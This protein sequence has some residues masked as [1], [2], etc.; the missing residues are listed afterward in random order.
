MSGPM[1]GPMR[2]GMR[3]GMKTKGSKKGLQQ[4][5]KFSKPYLVVILIAT[6]CALCSAI[7]SVVAPNKLGAVTDEITKTMFGSID[8]IAV[9][10]IVISLIG[11]YATS[12]VLSFIQ[13]FSM[14]TV[15]QK[16]AKRLRSDISH[17]INKLPLKCFDTTN[18]GDILS[19]I[20]NDVDL[21]AQSMNQSV[22]ALVSAIAL[23]LGSVIAMF[24]TNPIM[25]TVAVLSSILGF[26]FMFIV[27]GK[28]QKHFIAQQMLLGQLNGHIE[29]VYTGH[30]VVVAFNATN[31]LKQQ[32]NQT[33]DKLYTSAWKSQ[34]ASGIMMPMMHFIGNLGYVAVC[35]V[36]AVL[37]S[38]GKISFGVITS[39]I[40]YVRLF[41]QPLS[42]IGQ[43]ASSVQSASAASNRVFEFLELEET[44]D[45]SQKTKT[46]TNV[47]G[48]V[49]FEHVNFGYNADK[50]IINDF[51][52]NVVGG[53]KV[54]IVGPTGAG[55]T[56]LVNLLMRFY[57][58]NSGKISIDGVPINELTRENL[59]DLFGMVLQ[60]TWLFHGT[61][62]EN[63]AYSKENVSD[64]QIVQACKS[65]GIHHFICTLP[66]G[67]DTELSHEVNLSQGQKQLM[68]IARAMI[69]NA[70]MLILDE[71][72][73]SVDTRTELQIQRAMDTLSK[74]RTS[75]VIAH[76]LST[77]KNADVIIVMK[78]GDVVE[79]GTHDD[80][81]A[82]NGFYANLY[83]SQFENVSEQ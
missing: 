10:N 36:G 16:M 72:T 71:A 37:A 30:N 28:V 22:G 2:G 63:L 65:V 53:Q 69:E 55:K 67:Y 18:N 56:T 54:A 31:R 38:Q 20:T 29:E 41:S 33:N 46:L 45:E 74:G 1:R 23:I 70:P 27:I 5:I 64:E 43:S 4:L 82:K 12:F 51:S 62:K 60:D 81:L 14:S 15:T 57:E 66:K 11:F 9:K 35:V 79:S 73:S 68:T 59:H 75:F 40:V 49:S 7:L 32:F 42:Q 25:A 19:R 58:I 47:K 50:T 6:L 39:F 3:I 24:I 44:S 61:I 76:R 21:I 77:I 17:K 48:D 26:V 8:M 78:D 34:F 80:L 52:M 13:H 83:N